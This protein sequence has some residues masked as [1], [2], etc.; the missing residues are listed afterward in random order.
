MEIAN[1]LSRLFYSWLAMPVS[2]AVGVAALV[3]SIVLLSFWVNPWCSLDFKKQ[4][5]DRYM[6]MVHSIVTGFLGLFVGSFT[7][8]QCTSRSTW[9]CAPFLLLLGFLAV[10]FISMCICDIWQRW[11]PIDKGT[12]AHH[13]C[14][15]LLFICGYVEDVGIW[16]GSAL[17][18][19]E[20]S[21]P[22]LNIFWYLQYVGKKES[23]AFMIN[24]FALLVAFTVFRILYIPFSFYQFQARGFCL[25]STNHAYQSL[26]WVM[27]AGYIGIYALNMSWYIKLVRGALKATQ[28]CKAQ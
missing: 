9:V 3:W 14:I 2:L 19:N 6:S 25:Q 7:T 28:K 24:G 17:L 11:R 20:L 4:G 21:T 16:F 23:N 10:D 15:M 22:F 18:I 5:A 13:I 8:P 27:G 1:A 26:A 12:L